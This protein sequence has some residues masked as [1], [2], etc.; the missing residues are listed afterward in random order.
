MQKFHYVYQIMNLADGISYIGVRSSDLEPIKDSKYMG[1]SRHL[2]K[3][4]KEQGAE[5][6]NKQILFEFGSRQ[7]AVEMEIALHNFFDVA[8]NPNFY[9]KSKQKTSGFDTSGLPAHNRGIPASESTKEKLRQLNTG[10]V[11]YWKGK[12][13]PDE[14]REK[15]RQKLTGTKLSEETRKKL[16]AAHKGKRS[17][18]NHPMHGKHHTEES[19][20]QRSEKLK[21]RLKPESMRLKT[22]ENQ[23]GSKHRQHGVP[24][25]EKEKRKIS[26]G[27]KNRIKCTYSTPHGIFKT[28][29]EAAKYCDCSASTVKRRCEGNF[30]G[31]A[32]IPIKES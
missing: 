32:L 30:E 12:T 25:T 15:I 16:S 31:Y 1:S 11:G 7:E 23:K 4:I 3:A 2:A 19:N 28:A 14:V 8:V 10:K 26:E 13:L 5:N 29:A 17:G 18:E 6:F 22:S 21:G 27:L 24:R 9:N 20:I